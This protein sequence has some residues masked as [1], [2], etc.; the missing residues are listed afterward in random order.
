MWWNFYCVSEPRG[1][2]LTIRTSRLQPLPDSRGTNGSQSKSCAGRG[3]ALP[4]RRS[5]KTTAHAPT[6]QVERIE[7]AIYLIRGEKVMLDE[8]LASLYGVET[9][10]L[11][12][13]VN[14]NI[15]RFPGDFM[16]TLA[17]QEFADL[18]RQIGG[19][20]SWGGR[21]RSLPRAFTQEIGFRR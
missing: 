15:G 11:T 9:W 1:A 14:R 21:R 18:K 20:S 17:H 13:A 5:S 3:G 8:D 19:S 6:V 16:F 2:P 12:R 7:E 10:N 4:A